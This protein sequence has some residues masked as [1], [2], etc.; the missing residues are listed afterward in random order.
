[1]IFYGDS[2]LAP[3]DFLTIPQFL[4]D[5]H[6]PQRLI[7]SP[8]IPWLVDDPTGKSYGYEEIRARVQGLLDALLLRLLN[9]VS[10]ARELFIHQVQHS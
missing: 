6:Y 2:I 1:M 4:L 7:R 10:R 5:F 3:P 9:L 8:D